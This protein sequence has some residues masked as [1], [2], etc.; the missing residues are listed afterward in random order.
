MKTNRRKFISTT[1]AGSAAAAL[2][3]VSSHGS[4]AVNPGSSGALNPHYPRLD[5]ILNKPVLKREL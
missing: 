2:S 4:Q 5:E 3:T 1:L